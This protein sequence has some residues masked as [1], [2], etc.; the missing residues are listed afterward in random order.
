MRLASV[1]VRGAS[2][3][4]TPVKFGSTDYLLPLSAIGEVETDL[5]A[6][7]ERGCSFP[8]LAE[9]AQREA[10][11]LAD[12]NTREKALTAGRLIAAAE[13]RF[14]PPIAEPG[15]L[16]VGGPNHRRALPQKPT[17]PYAF[18]KFP[19]TMVGQGGAIL[20]PPRAPLIDYFGSYAA[21]IGRR[22][23]HVDAAGA[24]SI[25]A[26][27]VLMAEA[28]RRDFGFNPKERG[29]VLLSKSTDASTPIGPWFVSADELPDPSGIVIEYSRTSHDVVSFKASELWFGIDEIVSFASRLEL[30][31]GDIIGA[32]SD[33]DAGLVP[34]AADWVPLRPGDY[35]FTRSQSLGLLSNDVRA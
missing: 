18:F 5:K 33:T 4:V 6:L 22:A 12:A 8:E 11:R 2:H 9:K 26:G 1:S 27:Y 23:Q 15:K 21:V 29:S 31:P 28:S 24:R 7:L 13:A 30:H 10:D 34:V 17:F 20:V 14:Q 35:P 32:G 3:L 16:L 19:S 25:I